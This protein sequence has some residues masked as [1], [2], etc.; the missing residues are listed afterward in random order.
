VVVLG[1]SMLATFTDPRTER[2]ILVIGLALVAVLLGSLLKQA[3]PFI[4][5]VLVLP[6]EN[7]IVFIVQIGTNIAAL[8]WWITLATAGA[9]LLVIAVTYERRA[10]S[11]GVGAR[12]RDLR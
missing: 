12:L 7:A 8:P 1:T 6:I 11:K 5:G 3:A 4:L 10:S 2:A 9:A